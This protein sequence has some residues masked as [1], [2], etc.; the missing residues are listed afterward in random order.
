MPPQD[1]VEAALAQAGDCALVATAA[2]TCE[3]NLRW[4]ANSLTTNGDTAAT[5]V[6]IVAMHPDGGTATTSGQ[7]PDAATLRDLVMRATHAAATAQRD[8]EALPLPSGGQSS[9]W[10]DAPVP[11]DV[12]TLQPLTAGLG[13]ELRATGDVEHFGY[14]EVDHTTL[15]LGSTAGTRLRHVQRQARAEFTAKAGD[16]RRSAW[17]GSAQPDLAVDVAAVAEELRTALTHQ[18]TDVAV[19]PGRHRVILTPSATADLMIDM[20]YAADAR[21]AIEGRSVFAGP[22]GPRLGERVGVDLTLSSDPADPAPG[23]ACT[24]FEVTVASTDSSSTYDNGLPL[25]RTEW[26]SRGSLANL[27]TTRHTAAELGRPATPGI[28]NLT[29]AL[30]DG[31]GTLADVI[32]RTEHGLLITC[33]WYNRVVDPQTLLLTGL[34]RDGVYVVRDGRIVGSCGNFR[35]NESPVSLLGRIVDGSDEVRTLAREMGDYF[36]RAVMPALV[37]EDFNLSTA[38]EAH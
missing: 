33:L 35:F 21:S 12:A 5:Q 17:A 25:T 34:T 29:L 37:V 11:V 18:L 38:S 30:A 7:V 23:M 2:H 8:P 28:D 10:A 36:N 31:V 32:A 6:D 1:I 15:Y 16:R 19:A 4:A 3:V 22:S 13:A 24:P 27:W 20:Y 26:I 9:D 14:A